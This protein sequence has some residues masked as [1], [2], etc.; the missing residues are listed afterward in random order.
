MNNCPLCNKK[1]ELQIIEKQDKKTAF[2]TYKGCFVK[3]VV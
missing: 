3:Y 2:A 1:H